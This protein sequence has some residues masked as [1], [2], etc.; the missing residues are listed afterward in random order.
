MKD[1]ALQTI[2]QQ[3]QAEYRMGGLS[4][5]LYGDFAKDV[6][7]RAVAATCAQTLDVARRFGGIDGDDH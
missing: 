5:G 7:R 6:A 1:E 3:V 4:V 2:C